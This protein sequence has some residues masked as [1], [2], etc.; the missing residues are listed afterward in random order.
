MKKL[1]ECRILLV[2]DTKINIDILVQTLRSHYR[3]GVALSGQKAIEFALNNRVDL[4]LLDILMPEMDGFEVCKRLKNNP[5]T[6]DIPVIFI[7][8]MDAVSHKTEGF[9]TGAVDY[10]TKPFDI[11]E[12]QARV[13]THLS[14]KIAREALKNQNAILEE[15]VQERTRELEQ[16]Q[17]EIVDR[18]CLAAEHRD[19]DTGNHVRRMGQ[20]CYLLARKA[21]IPLTESNNLATAATLHDVGKIGVSDTIMLKPARLTPEEMEIM[22]THSEI[23]KNL[24]SG[25]R[26]KLLQTAETIALTHH[27]RWDGT[28]YPLGLQK[29]EIPIEGRIAGIC[30]VFDALVSNRPYKKAWPMDRALEEIRSQSGLHF[31]PELAEL[32][33]TLEP[34]LE[35]ILQEL[36]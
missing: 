10:I 28:G 4:I 27:E 22:R 15:M 31:D 23:G 18:L 5:N 1:S 13:K 35:N 6:R 14:L 12:V 19:E 30:D 24:L 7:S 2:D 17:I 3:L 34:D 16:T 25:S 21:G 33:L 26:C 20:Y 36:G 8:A 11:E 9:K 32:F 29:F